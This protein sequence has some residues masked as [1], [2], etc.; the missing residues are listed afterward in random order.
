MLHQKL[1]YQRLDAHRN[2]FACYCP[3]PTHNVIEAT[4][5]G[6]RSSNPC[7]SI[8]T[9]QSSTYVRLADDGVYATST[10]SGSM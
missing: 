2:I 7:A 1:L 9:K 3:T 4:I 8:W 5:A 10:I 6:E